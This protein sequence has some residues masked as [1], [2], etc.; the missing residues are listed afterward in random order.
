[1][2]EKIG[3]RRRGS[4]AVAAVLAL[5][6]LALTVSLAG[7][8]GAVQ[9]DAGMF[10]SGAR[11]SAEQRI[12]QIERNSGKMVQVITTP[13][14]NGRDIGSVSR[15][16]FQDQ[17]I[18]G[19][20]LYFSRDDRQLAIQVGQNTRGAITTQDEA[21]IRDTIVNHFSSNDFDG[22]LLAAIDQIGNDLVAAVPSNGPQ[23]QPRTSPQGQG[24][25]LMP[26]LL[27]GGA[28]LLVV[29]FVRSRARRNQASK[30][31]SFG[32]GRAFPP[33][34]GM[35]PMSGGFGGMG[36]GFL[37]GLGGSILGNILLGGLF[38]RGMGGSSRQDADP[39]QPDWMADDAGRVSGDDQVIGGWADA[40]NDGGVDIG[41]W[42]AGG[43]SGGD[44]G[45][46]TTTG[47]W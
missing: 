22:G 38:R 33:G 17:R 42:D 6:A 20:L 8:V 11:N 34:R 12:A 15:Q 3:T 7:A 29:L 46:D 16:A 2:N 4:A 10:S 28:I 30:A 18:N 14:L 32:T 35:S 19:V 45:G 40:Q 41:D 27:I 21:Q 26:I 25:S 43:L 31:G 5:I 23:T 39:A 13:S 36:G 47:Q 44:F 1:M 9:D 37:G 24:I